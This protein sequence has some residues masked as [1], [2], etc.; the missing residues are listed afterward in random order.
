MKQR[1]LFCLIALLLVAVGPGPAPA[2]ETCGDGCWSGVSDVDGKKLIFSTFPSEGMGVLFAR[3]LSEAYG[4]IGYSV[5]VTGLPAERALFM[6]DQ[7]VVD[8]EAARV[9]VI[10][11]DHA[12]LVRVPTPL[13]RN[14]VVV[15]TWRPEIDP[16]QGWEGLY[17]YSLASVIGYRFIEK[18][19]RHMRRQLVPCYSTL[20]AM[21]E[22]RRVDAVVS[23]YLEA[24]PTLPLFNLADVRVLKPPYAYKNMYHYLHVRHADLV[25]RIDAVLKAMRAEGRMDA[26]LH[27]LEHEYLAGNDAFLLR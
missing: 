14:R 22:V 19:T 6:A 2:S 12:N 20:F 3:I 8:G 24:L 23:E 7:G 16:A 1:I 21:L 11:E 25:S 13:Y 18:K 5:E 27:D 9:P 26:I 17:P 15:F 10:E 4:R